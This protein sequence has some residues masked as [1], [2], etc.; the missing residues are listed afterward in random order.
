MAISHL[1]FVGVSIVTIFLEGNL[2]K[3]SQMRIPFDL[4][5]PLVRIIPKETI[6]EG[7]DAVQRCL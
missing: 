4:K 3:I 1:L 7:K 5:V 6:G 2:A